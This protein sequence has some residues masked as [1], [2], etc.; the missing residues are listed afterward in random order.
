MFVCNECKGGGVLAYT[1]LGVDWNEMTGQVKFL[2]LVPHYT[3]GED[4]KIIQDK[5]GERERDHL[6]NL[7]F[8]FLYF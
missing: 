1:I 5:V 4:L 6:P 2:V 8:V 3:G 7:S